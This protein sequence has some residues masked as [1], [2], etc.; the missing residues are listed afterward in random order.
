VSRSKW[1]RLAILF[2]GPLANLLLAIAI[3]TVLFMVGLERP[4]GLDD[5]P[6][7]R[8]VAQ[9]SPAGRAGIVQGDRILEIEGRKTE[10]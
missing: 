7:I 8:Y 10:T 9:D 1:E 3:L 5:P 2:A 4:A 6:I